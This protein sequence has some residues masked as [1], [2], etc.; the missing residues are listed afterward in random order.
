MQF[1]KKAQITAIVNHETSMCIMQRTSISLFIYWFLLL[2]KICENNN[3]LWILRKDDGSILGIRGQ[4]VG[5]H[6]Q[7]YYPSSPQMG[8]QYSS[9]FMLKPFLLRG[10][11]LFCVS[12]RGAQA[13]FY[14]CKGG[15]KIVVL[16]T[17]VPEACQSFIASS[18][19]CRN[20][21]KR[22]GLWGEQAS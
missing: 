18:V 17:S 4:S 16:T 8:K 5:E 20:N 9:F 22:S 3:H 6:Y 19:M 10:K 21:V 1:N 7:Q 15:G 11:R 13:Y 2:L 14:M 12:Y